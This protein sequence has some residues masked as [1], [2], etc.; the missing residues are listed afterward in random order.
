M[1]LIFH[2][3]HKLKYSGDNTF[4]FS[5]D[6]K[7]EDSAISALIAQASNQSLPIPI[8]CTWKRIINKREYLIPTNKSK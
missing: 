1:S 6:S 8:K 5:L 3:D 4:T 2:P 7:R